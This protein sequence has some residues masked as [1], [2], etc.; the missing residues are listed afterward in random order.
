MLEHVW[1]FDA[2]GT[3]WE[4]D[5][6]DPLGIEQ[7]DRVEARIEEYDRTWSRFRSDSAVSLLR[8]Q[9]GE[10]VFP[11]EADA[12]FA[13]YDTLA[14]LTGGSVTPFVGDA[15]ETLGYDA[16]YSLVPRGPAAPAPSWRAARLHGG[17]AVHTEA[18]VVLDVG[19]AGKGH[20]VDLV[21]EELGAAGPIVV[22]ASGDLRA[23]GVRELTVALEHPYDPTRAIGVATPG[24]RALCASASNRRVWGEGLH[25]VLDGLTGRPVETVVATWAVAESALVADG[26][27]TALFV[28]SP[29]VLAERFEFDFVRVFSDGTLHSSP[30]FPG[31]VFR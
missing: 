9:P 15:L 25:H 22:D 1:R 8:S 21:L 28:C 2:I 31:E 5:S 14:E 13:L 16:D 26:L 7:R 27:A 3:A 17:V 23:R 11:P 30:H 10:H 18:G 24:E 29:D 19:A 4:I 6:V 20:L 12:L